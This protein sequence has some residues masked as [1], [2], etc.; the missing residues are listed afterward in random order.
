MHTLHNDPEQHRVADASI[1]WIFGACPLLAVT[2]TLTNGLGICLAILTATVLGTAMAALLLGRVH[3]ALR[4]PVTMILMAAIVGSMTL[5]ANAW[6]PSLHASM[7]IFPIL[8]AT[9]L[10]LISRLQLTATAGVLR[11]VSESVLSFVPVLL[12]LSILSTLRELVGRGS[13]FH[14]IGLIS[15][16]AP[17]N[18]DVQLFSADLGFLLALLPPGAF[19][20]FAVLLALRN[21]LRSRAPDQPSIHAPQ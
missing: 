9:N 18:L 15:A 4:L 8:I 7:G 11:A 3:R 5:V 1:L 6:L 17:N 19:I 16:R 21:W 2:D 10:L 13:L 12:L 20:S 14:D